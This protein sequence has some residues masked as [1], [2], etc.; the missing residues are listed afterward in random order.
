[1]QKSGQIRS[2][3]L[4]LPSTFACHQGFTDTWRHHTAQWT[5]NNYVGRP[6][7]WGVDDLAGS[8]VTVDGRD[9][10]P[11]LLQLLHYTRNQ[12][13]Q[14]GFTTTGKTGVVARP[15]AADR[16]RYQLA[17]YTWC[18]ACVPK[19]TSSLCSVHAGI[20][21][22]WYAVYFGPEIRGRDLFTDRCSYSLS[23]AAATFWPLDPLQILFLAALGI[24]L[25]VGSWI[26]CWLL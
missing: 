2:Q 3:G 20:S 22:S 17:L 6:V 19:W 5:R 12:F 10:A 23:T 26:D 1:M 16:R 4:W 11:A 25:P 9:L 24:P 15:T 7:Q 13:A 21:S 18:T 14:R 8:F